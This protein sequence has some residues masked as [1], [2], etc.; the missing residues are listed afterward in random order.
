VG[1]SNGGLNSR[2]GRLHGMEP[3]AGMTTIKAEV[4]MAELLTYAQSLASMTGGPGEYS[5]Q[6]PRYEGG[7]RRVLDALPPR[8]GG[9]V[10]RRQEGDRGDAEVS[11]SRPRLKRDEE[12]PC[13]G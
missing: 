8:R 11:R 10:T 9:A 7:Q 1:A 4:P 6:F 12:S 3:A 5:T 2:R 13:I